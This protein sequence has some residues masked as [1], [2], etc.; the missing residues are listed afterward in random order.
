MKAADFV[1]SCLSRGASV[2]CP[3]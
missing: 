2:F 3:M 1:E